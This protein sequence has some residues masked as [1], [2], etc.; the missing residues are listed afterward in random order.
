[1][2]VDFA[3]GVSVDRLVASVAGGELQ[4]AGRLT[5]ALAANASVHGVDAGVL[6]VF[7]PDIAIAGTLSA[8]ADLRGTLAAPQG[9]IT[10][11][12]RGLRAK[13]YSSKAVAPA[14]LDMRGTLHGRS[15]TV[16]ATLKAGPQVH[17]TLTGE[18]G[19]SLQLHSE[20]ALDLAMF[21]PVLVAGG[22]QA[23]GKVALNADIAGSIAAPRVTGLVKL[24]EGEIQDFARGVHVT[25]ISAG[26]RADGEILHIVDLKA[27]AG[28]GTIT[29]HG[30]IDLAQPGWPIELAIE[31][32][33]A[34]PI[35]S[36]L[37]TATL[38]G[39][40]AVT[41]K[42]QGAVTVCRQTQY[43]AWRDQS[44]GT[45][46]ARGRRA[47]RAPQRPGATTAGIAE[48]CSAGCRRAHLRSDFRARARN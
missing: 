11:Q 6:K 20:G 32:N 44:A 46:P 34:R 40:L 29:G 38:S 15:A 42:L 22:R 33:E 2:S 45:L 30:T 19:Q 21:N 14:D 31:A 37:L 3:K 47:G 43:R 25:N 18:A 35:V 4:L 16:N 7:V 41:G 12:G 24:A 39:N 17:L 1:M 10:L 8:T 28:D 5:P 36:D 23:K 48:R 27:R 9:P 26:I 13:N